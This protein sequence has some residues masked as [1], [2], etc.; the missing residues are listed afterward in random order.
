M[1][2]MDARNVNITIKNSYKYSKDKCGKCMNDEY[3]KVNNIQE[4]VT[5]FQETMWLC[6][7]AIYL[8]VEW[9]KK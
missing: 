5:F 6:R 2:Y 4:I 7:N 3:V 8:I 9:F 1:W